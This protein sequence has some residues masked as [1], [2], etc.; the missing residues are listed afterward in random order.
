MKDAN[1]FKNAI[2]NIE[3]IF[4]YSKDK[5]LK[6]KKKYKILKTLTSIL[7]PVDTV[8]NIGATTTSATLPV[9][10]VDLIVAPNS[11]RSASAL[12]LANKILHEILMNKYNRYRKQLEK[13]QQTIKSFV[14]FYRK[15][16]QDN[17]CNKKEFKRQ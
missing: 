3:E 1:C 5:N 14:K 12:S 17:L 2:K 10:G 15:S 9:T 11:A 16:Y 6:P 13:D 8:V 4:T 7:E